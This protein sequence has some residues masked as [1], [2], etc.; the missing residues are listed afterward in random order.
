[1]VEKDAHWSASGRPVS[2]T[3]YWTETLGQAQDPPERLYLTVGLGIPGR[4]WNL[5]MEIKRSALTFLACCHQ[6]PP[7]GNVDEK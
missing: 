4:S 2:G 5:W 3:S 7:P 1:M 6:E